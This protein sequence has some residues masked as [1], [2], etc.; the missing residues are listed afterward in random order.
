VQAGRR[1]V[2]VESTIHV[3]T[4]VITQRKDIT[5]LKIKKP[6]SVF[7]C[8]KFMMDIDIADKYLSFHSDLGKLSNG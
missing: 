7:Q 8:S 4:V 2:R 5:N 3:A 6:N 1:L